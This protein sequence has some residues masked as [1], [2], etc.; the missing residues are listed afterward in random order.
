MASPSAPQ[1]KIEIKSESKKGYLYQEGLGSDV[2]LDMVLI[3]GGPF[4]MGSSETEPERFDDEGP[5]HQVTVPSFAIGRYPIT[6][7]QWKAVAALPQIEIELNPEPSHFK[8]AD[9][10]VESISWHEAKEFCARL[11][12]KTKR[13]YR[14][15]TEAEWEYACRAR[16]ETP[17][18]SGTETPFHFGETITTDLVNYNGS[19]YNGGPEG[20]ERG[21]TTS[22]NFFEHSNAFGLHDMHGNVD[23][24]CEDHWHG[25][26]SE[27]PTDGSACLAGNKDTNRVLRGGS[28][29]DSPRSCRSAIRLYDP[30][31]L[32]Y[33]LIGLRVVCSLLRT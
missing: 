3:Q 32:R 11:T 9:R 4:W 16:T 15:P 25:D 10:P 26:Y 8:G 19:S 7:A 29:N 5:R 13:S 2:L 31:D 28:W 12:D 6:Q 24:W 14:L 18:H 23:E 21:E 1:T 30:P 17:F 22:V 27:A 20:K 33:N